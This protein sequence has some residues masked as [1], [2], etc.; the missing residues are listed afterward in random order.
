MDASVMT[1]ANIY[2]L[3]LGYM[4]DQELLIIKFHQVLN[5]ITGFTAAL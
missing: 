3:I 5:P 4:T 2:P 1:I